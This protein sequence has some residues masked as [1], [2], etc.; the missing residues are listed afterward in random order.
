MSDPS[1]DWKLL[2]AS[3][4]LSLWASNAGP[5]YFDFVSVIATRL[6]TLFVVHQDH[7]SKMR[8]LIHHGVCAHELG[9]RQDRV[10]LGG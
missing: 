6:I 3:F 5:V 9:H 2:Y 8:A 1:S 7:F 10:N 4:F